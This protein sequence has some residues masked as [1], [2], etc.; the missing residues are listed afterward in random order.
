[1]MAGMLAV[2]YPDL[3]TRVGERAR[4][5]DLP[6]EQIGGYRLIGTPHIGE[7]DRRTCGIFFALLGLM[8]VVDAELPES[9]EHANREYDHRECVPPQHARC[10]PST[11]RRVFRHDVQ[12][13]RS[14]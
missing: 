12:G 10:E 11:Q 6:I 7:W 3:I 4:D 13:L 1:F 2:R 5:G 9:G 14:G 8:R